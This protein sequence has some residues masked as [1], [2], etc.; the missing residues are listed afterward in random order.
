MTAWIEATVTAVEHRTARLVSVMLDAPLADHRAGQHL[1]VQ[2]TAPDGYAARR[3]Y[4]IAS[5][6][7]ARPFELLIERLE[8][9]EVSPYF[10]EV[11]AAGDTIDVRGPLGGHFVWDEADGGPLLLIGGGSGIA[12]LLSILAARN[13]SATPVPTLMMYSARR[14]DDLL[15]PAALVELE[16]RDASFALTLVTTRDQR[17]RDRDLEHRLDEPSI[18][19]ILARWG[20]LPRLAYVCGSNGF[21]ETVSTALVTAGI[22]SARIRTERYGSD[23]STAVS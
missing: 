1:D 19:D 14:W 6:P 20:R 8:D 11:A 4:S 17:R 16:A 21:V 9:G 18:A 7:R 22:A 5:A 10:H 15:D 2:L 3:S 12:P 23:S 13:A